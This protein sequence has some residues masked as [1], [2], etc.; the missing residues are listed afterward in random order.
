MS[1]KPGV[2]SA[3]SASISSRPRPSTR[4][5]SV[6]MPSVIPTSAVRADAPV[7]STTVP[8]RITR[9]FTPPT[10]GLRLA[11]EHE[12]AVSGEEPSVDD[13]GLALVHDEVALHLD[14][15]GV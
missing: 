7:P 10:L 5:T 11:T 1:T 2:T 6:M 4:P 9:S 14:A 8:P 3:P 13:V 15:A 12:G